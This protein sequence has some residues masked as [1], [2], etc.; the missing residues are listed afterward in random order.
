MDL[1]YTDENL[2]DVNIIQDYSFD[3]EYGKDSDNTFQCKV[4][5]YNP[6]MQGE[7]RIRPNCMLYVEFTE[8]G[9]IIDT[10]ESNT[11]NGEVTFKGRTWH[12]ILNSKVLI[13]DDG[14][15]IQYT[16]IEV[17][18]FLQDI[19][20]RT[21]LQNIFEVDLIDVAHQ[22][23]EDIIK[24]PYCAIEYEK[25]YDAILKVFSRSDVNAKLIAF[26]RSGKMHIGAIRL[27]NYATDEEFDRSQVP[28]KVGETYNC[29]N[30]LV[31]RGQGKYDSRPVIHLFTDDGGAIQPYSTTV[32][33]AQDSDY[34]L[35]TRNQK[36]FGVNECMDILD[37]PN[38]SIV[39][40]YVPQTTKP[41]NW[42]NTY[43]DYYTAEW[44][45]S[46]GTVKYVKVEKKARDKYVKITKKPANWDFDF[47]NYF[48]WVKDSEQKGYRWDE[49]NKCYYEVADG[50]YSE[51]QS[52]AHFQQLKARD[53]SELTDADYK[54]ITQAEYEAMGGFW[55]SNYADFYE[56]NVT[57]WVSAKGDTYDTYNL[58]D[59]KKVGGSW[60]YV[61]E[62]LAKAPADWK[63]NYSSYFTRNKNAL[64]EWVYTAVE[65]VHH[66]AHKLVKRKKAP[67]DWQTDWG[68]YYVCVT[69]EGKKYG[70]IVKKGGVYIKASTAVSKKILAKEKGKDYVKYE[71]N[72]FYLRV[73]KDD[74][75]PKFT[76][77]T[78]GVFIKYQHT[79]APTFVYG[80]Y[81]RKK[82]APAFV[83]NASD[84]TKCIYKKTDSVE[85]IPD[86]NPKL[87]YKQVEDRY[88]NLVKEGIEELE[89][90][91]DTSTL[92]ISLELESNYDVGDI[93]GARDDLLYLP[94]NKPI[95][96][97]IIRIKKE[98]VSV[99]YEVDNG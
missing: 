17:N 48:E 26:F 99:D 68:S 96:R 58:K 72:K 62:P 31:C 74:T 61:G 18:A 28:F 41:A 66:Y 35:D 3:E 84:P 91:R 32:N 54:K 86:F 22:D 33:P 34:I 89:K 21:G 13:P 65:G 20:N 52:G 24:I 36:V 77:F 14:Y 92:D 7:D 60:K 39:Y 29:L 55:K 10:V 94:V 88:A 47:E 2:E 64:N 97:K 98:I 70:K 59:R 57:E 78:N 44:D 69:K 90:Y 12:G 11:K 45:E 87:F 53:D 82:N 63:W 83:Y 71:P 9:G 6:V 73:Q 42:K 76:G 80:K 23:P 27:I 79:I 40:N 5:R 49:A 81:Y 19:V 85:V 50:E 38:A 4:Q 43:T 16:D 30:H 67:D 51:M 1:I 46:K 37:L 56:K 75:P 95:L 93:I 25:A 8:Y 15:C